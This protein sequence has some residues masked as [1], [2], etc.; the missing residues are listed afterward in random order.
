M[1]GHEGCNLVARE[2]DG[3]PEAQKLRRRILGVRE[4]GRWVR[5]RASGVCGGGLRDCTLVA[6]ANTNRLQVPGEFLAAGNLKK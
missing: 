1:R 6:A 5:Q 4:N 2:A 3:L